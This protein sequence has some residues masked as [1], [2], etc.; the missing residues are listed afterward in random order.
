MCRKIN[1]KLFCILL[2]AYKSPLFPISLYDL[3]DLTLQNNP[4]IIASLTDYESSLVSLK[5]LNGGFAPGFSLSSSTSLSK[6]YEWNS[7]PDFFSASFTYTQ[8]LPGGTDFSITGNYS[9]NSTIYNEERYISLSPKISFSLTQSLLP[10]WAQGKIVDP[11][12]LDAIQQ[13]EYYHYQNIYAK[14]T[15]LQNLIQNYAYFLIYVNEIQIYENSISLIEE[16]ISATKKLKSSGNTNQAMITELENTKW[17]YEENLMS[18]QSNYFSSL[19]NI[20]SICGTNIE[21][22]LEFVQNEEIPTKFL[23]LSLENIID[24]MD[25]IFQLKL[26]MLENRYVLQKQS[27]APTLNLTIQPSWSLENVKNTEWITSRKKSNPS[28]T[29]TISVDFSPL[30]KTTISQ[31]NKHYEID[32]EQTK[33]SYKNYL[34]QKKFVQEQYMFLLHNYSKQLEDIE[35]L[36]NE[37]KLELRDYERLFKIGAISKLDY[38]S[39]RVKVENYKLSRNCVVI[40]KWLCNIFQSL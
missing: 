15:V 1:L 14:K 31:D 30:L 22:S 10:F 2:I 29:G 37:G 25:L 9:F 17:S 38:D 5:T 28:W 18:V 24:P 35:K 32:Y 21:E 4:D 20:K 33:K 3:I 23:I 27:S 12:I 40:Y 36:Y 16:Q 34:Q 39:V 7:I 11:T 26:Q 13:T 8:P 19:Q 6:D